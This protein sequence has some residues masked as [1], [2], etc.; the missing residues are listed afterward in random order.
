MKHTLTHLDLMLQP[1]RWQWPAQGQEPPAEA[2]PAGRWFTQ[3]A[4]L[5]LGLPAP[6]RKLLAAGTFS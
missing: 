3:E 4:A 2:L 6:I 5:A 1:L